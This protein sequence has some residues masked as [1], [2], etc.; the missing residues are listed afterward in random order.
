MWVRASVSPA[1]RLCAC[2]ACALLFV[3]ALVRLAA[4]S[5]PPPPPADA[6]ALPCLHLGRFPVT[7]AGTD[8]TEHNRP[9]M[10]MADRFYTPVIALKVCERAALW[11]WGAAHGMAV[12]GV[13]WSDGYPLGAR[14]EAL[15]DAALSAE[16]Y[17]SLE[18]AAVEA[19]APARS[20]PPD[21]RVQA[22]CRRVAPHALRTLPPPRWRA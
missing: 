8:V 17:A 5:R 22:L 12:W 7:R 16:Q 18:R 13:A 20:G 19:G 4:S 3:C 1:V 15:R 6:Y 11:A 21:A 14:Q 9:R 10:P 2:C